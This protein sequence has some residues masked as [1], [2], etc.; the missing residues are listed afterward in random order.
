MITC[1]CGKQLEPCNCHAQLKIPQT[2]PGVYIVVIYI[3]L[4]QTNLQV[5]LSAAWG[6]VAAIFI[7]AMPVFSESWEIRSAM[8][9]QKL[10]AAGEL[11]LA[12]PQL[13]SLEERGNGSKNLTHEKAISNSLLMRGS[14]RDI[15]ASKASVKS[16]QTHSNNTN[17]V[18]IESDLASSDTDHPRAPVF[19]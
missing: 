15:A 2:R 16:T 9:E 3:S 6:F 12:K 1:L 8:K 7:I 19:D 18:K 17:R 4:L 10:I 5:Q 13:P 14:D 11:E